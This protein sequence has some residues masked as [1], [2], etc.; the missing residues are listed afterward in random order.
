MTA[1]LAEIAA[2]AGVSEATVSRVLNGKPGVAAATRQNVFAALDVLGQ[3]H[4]ARSRRRSAGLVGLITP[5]LDNPI[6][7]AFA[8][9]IERTLTLHGFTPVLCTQTPGG[10][11]EDEFIQTL[12]DRDVSGIVFVSGLHAD[13]MARHDRYV[14]LAESAVPIVLINGYAENVPAAFF[15]TDD[16]AAM[17]LAVSHLTAL[18]HTRI[19]LAIGPRRF[20][21]VLRKLEGFLEAMTPVVGSAEDA[22]KLVE[23]SLFSFE[24]GF[25]AASLL[26]DR[27]CTAIVCGSD[28]M[29]LGAIRAARERGLR[30]P[31]DVSVVGFDD[32]PLIPYTDPPLTT[33]RQ[34]VKALG[35]AAVQTLLEEINGA[36]PPTGEFVFAPEL[37]VRGSTA[38]CT[39]R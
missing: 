32:S 34:P 36:E 22:R 33:V 9:I 6:F 39:D 2:Q 14:R 15:S 25:S 27:E 1:R 13:T 21:P 26:L 24:G 23:H 20:V 37:V 10:A 12:V 30:V 31:E 38:A 17:R 18:G 5:E 16:R 28:L 3:E 19:G 29:A 11:T 35:A 4:P 7:P 8:Q